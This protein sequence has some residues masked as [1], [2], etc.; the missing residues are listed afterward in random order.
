[1]VCFNSAEAQMRTPGAHPRLF[2]TADTLMQLRQLRSSAVHARIWGNLEA[3]ADWC[4]DIEPRTAWIAPR[5]PDPIYENLYDR[6]YAM[7][8]DM[9]VMEHLAF[10]FAYSGEQRYAEAGRRW[11]LCGARVWQHEADGEADASKAYAVMRLIKGLAISYDL[12]YSE[13]PETEAT[14]IR[15]TIVR[16]GR[17][18]HDWYVKNPGMAGPGQDK[19]HGSVE[20]SSLG[21]AALAVLGEAPEAADWLALMVKKHREY[22]IPC[23]LTPDG[24]HQDSSNFWASTMQYRIMFMDALR[25]VTGED[26]FQGADPFMD[27]RVALAA[28]V[29]EKR[30][31]PNEDN[32]SI[33]FGP[34]YGQLDYWSPVLVFLARQYRRPIYQ[35]LALW[36]HAL[37]SLQTTRYTTHNGETLLFSWGGYAY[38]W[39]DP[40]VEPGVEPGL[41]LSFDFPS[42]NE[43]Y[44]RASYELHGLAAVVRRGRIVVHAGGHPVL[45][46]TVDWHNRPSPVRD[47][48]LT[49]DGQ[50][51]TI[52]CRGVEDTPYGEQT[53]TLQRPARMTIERHE[54]TGPLRWWCHGRPLHD[55][56]RFVWD[57]G[58]CLEI[59]GGAVTSVDP[60]G[61]EDI[62]I[63]GLGKLTLSD[64]A[65]LRYPLVEIGPDA[66]GTIC[67][68]IAGAPAIR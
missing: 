61:H 65:P 55:G 35:H 2:F 10:A 14:E 48:Q 27:G 32:R 43:A 42:V 5:S 7:M 52:R 23:A 26:L 15:D 66:D 37:G 6:F 44:M 46:E 63:V 22:L 18:Y 67:I 25:R 62:K 1:M 19:H 64:P 50:I 34:S 29:G 51:A 53:I 30:P 36:D 13:M 12:L 9:A 4:L 17:K 21:I 49:D 31:G 57:G 47:L 28:V 58:Q 24:N 11:A 3:S 16:V 56:N 39:Y 45:I 40:S 8:H 38:A 60:T 68:E 59:L 54:V 33:L 41:P 20:A